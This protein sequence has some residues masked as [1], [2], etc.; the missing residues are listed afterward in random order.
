MVFNCG[1]DRD[2]E[3]GN[4]G[5][6]DSVAEARIKP[7][8]SVVGSVGWNTWCVEKRL[9]DGVISLR[10]WD[11]FSTRREPSN[12]K[13]SRTVKNN[14]VIE[15][16]GHALR[17][18]YR[19]GIICRIVTYSDHDV[20]GKHSAC[21]SQLKDGD[22]STRGNAARKTHNGDKPNEKGTHAARCRHFAKKETEKQKGQS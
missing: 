11:T 18:E 20:R 16:C 3:D 17:L 15:L 5:A 4:R 6:I 21:N 19:T 1:G 22:K 12:I 13:Q 2:C 9:G 14:D 7:V 10:N 8:D